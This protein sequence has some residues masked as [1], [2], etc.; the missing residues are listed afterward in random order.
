LTALASTALS[1]FLR[2]A[3]KVIDFMAMRKKMDNAVE[4][5]AVNQ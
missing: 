2:H 5:R 3:E 4:A 1:I